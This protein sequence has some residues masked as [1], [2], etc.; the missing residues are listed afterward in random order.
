[1]RR[2]ELA[3]ARAPSCA[4][5]DFAP[6][7]CRATRV[8]GEPARCRGSASWTTPWSS[9]PRMYGFLR[10]R[11]P[12]HVRRRDRI[13][14]AA[15]RKS[16]R[17]RSRA[18]VR[19]R[20]MCCSSGWRM[21]R[22]VVRR[23][24]F[25]SSPSLLRR[26]LPRESLRHPRALVRDAFRCHARDSDGRNRGLDRSRDRRRPEPT[27][28][29]PT[30]RFRPTAV[31]IAATVFVVAVA[32]VTSIVA[33]A[34]ARVDVTGGAALSIDCFLL[35]HTAIA[36]VLLRTVAAAQMTPRSCAGQRRS[37]GCGVRRGGGGRVLL[38]C[39]VLVRIWRWLVNF[40]RPLLLLCRPPPACTSAR[41]RRSLLSRSKRAH[42][43]SSGSR[44]GPPGSS[45]PRAQATRSANAVLWRLPNAWPGG[46][47][48]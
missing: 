17:G 44:G 29:E 9:G 6:F 7:P 15:L 39:V 28:P 22:V 19:R 31:A 12:V 20:L 41:A 43:I 46:A 25:F 4:I 18:K 1:M 26:L 30:R 11:P 5:L 23:R 48:P 34:C 16:W 27:W 14:R 35:P 42:Y 45:A 21:A 8:L 2:R 13:R 10:Y 24:F 32:H 37:G 38:W 33:F 47:V 40:S 3:R 36:A